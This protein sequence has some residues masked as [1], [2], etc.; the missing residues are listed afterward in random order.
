MVLSQCSAPYQL[1]TTKT[2]NTQSVNDVEVREVETEEKRVLCF[3]P[4]K[5]G[6]K[7]KRQKGNRIKD[8]MK[9]ERG[10]NPLSTTWDKISVSPSAHLFAD[11]RGFNSEYSIKDIIEDVEC[12][13]MNMWT[14]CVSV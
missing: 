12:I 7:E 8:E 14:G 13:N 10:D 9:D 11:L 1:N 4:A 6:K 2:T 5:P 3:I